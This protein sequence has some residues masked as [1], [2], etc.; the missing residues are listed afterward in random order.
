MAALTLTL[1]I[2]L[3]RFTT[4]TSHRHLL[5][6]PFFPVESDPPTPSPSS[7]PHPSPIPKMPFSSA[8][9][10]SPTPPDNKPFWR[11]K[12]ECS[13]EGVAQS[14]TLFSVT[15]VTCDMN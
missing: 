7:S 3:L 14:F 2:F 12:I 9:S 11:E 15:C 6:Q 8:S 10:S 5:H 1:F 13:T 4:A